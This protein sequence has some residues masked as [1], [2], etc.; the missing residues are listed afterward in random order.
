MME[1]RDGKNLINQNSWTKEF[2]RKNCLRDEVLIV[3]GGKVLE[4]IEV[5]KKREYSRFDNYLGINIPLFVYT[6]NDGGCVFEFIEYIHGDDSATIF[7]ALKDERGR[8]F[9]ESREKFE[10]NNLQANS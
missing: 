2:L 10:K 5:L 1:V 6:T 8:V 9:E 7:L 3:K 4:K